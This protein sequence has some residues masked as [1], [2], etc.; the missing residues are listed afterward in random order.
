MNGVDPDI[1]KRF[2]EATKG[3]TDPTK[4]MVVDYSDILARELAAS[5]KP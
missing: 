5:R 4:P 1:L 3:T 2:M